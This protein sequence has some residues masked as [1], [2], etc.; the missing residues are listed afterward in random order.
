MG[1]VGMILYMMI[2]RFSIMFSVNQCRCVLSCLDKARIILQSN[3]FLVDNGLLESLLDDLLMEEDDGGGPSVFLVNLLVCD[4]IVYVLSSDERYGLDECF[5]L[6]D[7]Y[8]LSDDSYELFYEH[9]STER[10]MSYN[11]VKVLVE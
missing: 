10:G 3:N 7:Y 4:Y 8:C 1:W 5:S 6:F 11:E 2:N 9:F